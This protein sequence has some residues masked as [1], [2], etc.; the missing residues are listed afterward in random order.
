MV[1]PDKKD[2]K[3]GKKAKDEEPDKAPAAMKRPASAAIP[4]MKRPATAKVAAAVSAAAPATVAAAVSA[5]A[6]A[7]AAA[8]TASATA[9]AREQPSDS[10]P[11]IPM[12]ID[13]ILAMTA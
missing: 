9:A 7:T 10:E 1:E 3:P 8:A 12:S 6:R 4:K 11:E 5:A 2:V 13:E